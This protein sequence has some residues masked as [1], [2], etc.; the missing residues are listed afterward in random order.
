MQ[1]DIFY[2]KKKKE[3]GK[4]MVYCLYYKLQIEISPKINVQVV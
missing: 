4:V 2:I 3:T 1:F